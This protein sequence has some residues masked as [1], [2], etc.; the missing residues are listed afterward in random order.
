MYSR[1]DFFFIWIWLILSAGV[2]LRGQNQQGNPFIRN[3]TRVE[4]GGH[5]QNW[6]VI[7]DK[8]GVMYLGNVDGVLEY[9]GLNWRLLK[10]PNF[11]MV[12]SLGLGN[13]GRI[14]VGGVDEMGYLKPDPF[15]HMNY[16]SLLPLLPENSEPPGD[17]WS[18]LV[19]SHGIYLK[20]SSGF[21]HLD[22][23]KLVFIPFVAHGLGFVVYDTVYF[24]G[25]A[26]YR[27]D[28]NVP[29]R[30]PHTEELNLETAGQVFVMPYP[31]NRLLIATRSKG[32]YLYNQEQLDKG[33]GSSAAGKIPSSV[34]EKFPAAVESYVL[35]KQLYIC[36]P[37]ARGHYALS[38]FNGGIVVMDRNGDWVRL[39]DKKCGL[40]GNRIHDVFCDHHD[41]LWVALNNGISYIQINSP[42]TFF[43]DSSGLE[44]TVMSLL[45]YKECLYAATPHGLFSLRQ[46]PT[47]SSGGRSDFIPVDNIDCCC[48][49]LTQF[50]G[51]LLVG[52]YF[53]VNQVEG[54][55]SRNV[56]SER[57]VYSFGQTHRFPNH[58][59]LGLRHGLTVLNF[60]ES[61]GLQN[62]P[63]TVIERI[64]LDGINADIRGIF[65]DIQGNL[66]LV[67]QYNGVWYMEFTGS[68]PNSFRL[69]RFGIEHGLPR[70]D[71]NVALYEGGR[72]LVGTQQGLYQAKSEDNSPFD[73]TMPR[74]F[75]EKRISSGLGIGA[76]PVSALATG[77]DGSVWV[78][79]GDAMGAF[80]PRRVDGRRFL[81]TPFR[82]IRGPVENLLV[83]CNHTAWIVTADGLYRFDRD[84]EKMYNAP[85][86]VLIRDI[87]LHRGEALPISSRGAKPFLS[88]KDNSLT[89]EYSAVYFENPDEMRYSYM[90]EGFTSQWSPWRKE[91]RAVFTNVPEGEYRFRVKARNVFLCESSAD[92]YD[93]IVQ[94][95]WYRT[96]FAY[97]VYTLLLFCIIATAYMLH[98]FKVHQAVLQERR[99]YEKCSLDPEQARIY[100]EKL[101]AIMESQKPYLDP[102]LSLA[103]LANMTGIKRHYIS[104]VLNINLHKTFWD[105]IKEYRIEE[106][107]EIL[108]NPDNHD[109][110][111]M[112]VAMEVG[113][114]SNV[115]FNQAFK[116]YTRTTPS[117]FK[118]K[119]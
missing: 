30:L 20:T 8:R 56:Y 91:S 11:S 32:F 80:I 118:S 49:A 7:Q 23:G 63:L 114:N 41:N 61:E 83:D 14:Y 3:F 25:D 2:M 89:F 99:K 72:V 18:T 109:M 101:L 82:K 98:K 22:E 104:Q 115:T 43:N 46:H 119:K 71:W 116:K 24:A 15:G 47:D 37:I 50:N 65:S 77:N 85:F 74:F 102:N 13:D 95:P 5:S 58:L 17:V 90:L 103:S 57:L 106:A 105:F 1:R 96:W 40:P 84:F 100:T 75:P 52:G 81:E 68:H 110:S 55:T 60:R 108:S 69:H 87:R 26:L 33:D 113:F 70:L 111:M 73:A 35:D 78:G 64:I 79:I 36:R 10:L 6:A 117:K 59:F 107:K 112:Q 12:R 51:H 93:F 88:Y 86:G 27:L 9:D 28:G 94:P 29:R 19:T 66:W 4:Y 54:I 42:I 53:G 31:G 48:W 45:Y 44:G 92:Y 34:L 76:Q 97:S 21:Y 62:H 67:T 16:V 39:L 38:T